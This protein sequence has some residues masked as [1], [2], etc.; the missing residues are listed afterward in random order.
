MPILPGWNTVEG[1]ARWGNVF[2][3]LGLVALA[4]LVLF[5][6][7]AFL[8]GRRE[9]ELI[10]SHDVVQ[11]AQ[12]EQQRA[13][14]QEQSAAVI[15]NLQKRLNITE[16]SHKSTEQELQKSAQELT[17]STQEITALK[18]R[19]AA[20]HLTDEQKKKLEALLAPGAGTA[21]K[22]IWPIG[23]ADGVSYSNDFIDAFSK[24][25]WKVGPDDIA[26][27]VFSGYPL[28]VI[29]VVKRSDD[30]TA[31]K[32]GLLQRALKEIGIEAPGELSPNI[33]EGQIQLTIGHKN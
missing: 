21:V 15:N 13:A 4:G 5:D 17:K 8:Y 22:I 32:A 11:A 19:Q 26:Q 27:G 25:G 16:Q 6:V 29:I 10:T 9:K 20:R 7:L 14:E 18:E 12:R 33:A 24:A 30:L 1:A 23:M 28:G 31:Q 3:V 2:T